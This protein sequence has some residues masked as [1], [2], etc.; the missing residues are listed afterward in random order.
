MGRAYFS[1]FRSSGYYFKWRAWLPGLKI[2]CARQK[3]IDDLAVV[4]RSSKEAWNGG[5]QQAYP[6]RVLQKCW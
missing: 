5:L 1:S 2:S 4:Y 6:L 3:C